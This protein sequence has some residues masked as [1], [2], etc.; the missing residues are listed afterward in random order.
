MTP[1]HIGAT[2]LM[3]ASLAGLILWIL[4]YVD[5]DDDENDTDNIDEDGWDRTPGQEP[6]WVG[7]P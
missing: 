4:G 6:K 2:L 1:D 7:L 5:E 3:V